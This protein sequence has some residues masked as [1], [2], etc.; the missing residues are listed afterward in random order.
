MQLQLIEIR[1]QRQKEWFWIDNEFI[2]TFAKKVGP[3]ATLVYVALSRHADQGTQTAFPSM[4]T[5][6]DEVGIKSRNTIAKGIKSLERH[7]IIATKEA[8]DPSNGKRLNNTYT[9][10]SRKFWK[11]ASAFSK[12]PKHEET[13]KK[14]EAPVTPPLTDNLKD[15]LYGKTWLNVEAWARW[16]VYRKEIKKTLTTSTI[17]S[18]IKLL[19]QH[20][21]DHVEMIDRSIQNGW[22]GLFPL[23]KDYKKPEVKKVEAK[24][25][26]YAHLS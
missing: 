11:G 25:G 20:Q 23:R 15:P 18:Q 10:L 4:Q 13:P 19:E 14:V 1:D 6:G 17:K 3:V 21:S 12:K 5:I 8:I 16:V 22:T 24:K 26:K 2:D 9:L 7:G